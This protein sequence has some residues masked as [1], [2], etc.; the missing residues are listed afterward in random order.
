MTKELDLLKPQGDK[1]IRIMQERGMRI[2]AINIVYF[3]GIN[4]DLKTINNDRL[5]GWN[6]VRCLITDK[7]DML[8]SAV[9]TTEPG[10]FYTYNRMNPKG[11]FRIKLNEQFRDCWRI[12]RHFTQDALVQIGTITGHRDNNQDGKRTNDLLDTGNY[13]HVNQ[14]TTSNAPN[15]VGRW[16]AGCLVGRFPSTHARFMTILRGSGNKFF[17]TVVFDGQEL[18]K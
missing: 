12:G 14:H 1:T 5:D 17:D 10:L 16:S 13:F 2:R 3:E 7:G 6:D 11:A 4:T 8:M 18:L 9:A 15:F